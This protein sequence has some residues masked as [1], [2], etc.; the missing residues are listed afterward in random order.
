MG[1]SLRQRISNRTVSGQRCRG[2]C[3]SEG[4]FA[5][6]HVPDRCGEPAGDV[7][8]RDLGATLFAEP[9]LHPLVAI[10]IDGMAAGVD[11]R[12]H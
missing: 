2:T 5:G 11:R 1:V 3:R 6:E 9:P 10:P 8:L 4:L 7:N 12:F